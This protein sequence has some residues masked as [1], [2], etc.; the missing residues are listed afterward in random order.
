VDR[1]KEQPVNIEQLRVDLKAAKERLSANASGLSLKKGIVEHP[2]IA[3]GAAF[4][5]G[6]ALG[7]SGEAQTE[8]AR[9]TI[10]VIGKE[11]INKMYE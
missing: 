6:A 9:M 10:E 8:I 1:Q 7:A 4:V 11:L 2:F 5:A 3:L